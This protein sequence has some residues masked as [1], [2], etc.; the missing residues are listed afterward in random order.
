MGGGGGCAFSPALLGVAFRPVRLPLPCL[1]CLWGS[2][3]S[4]DDKIRPGLEAGG[5]LETQAAGCSPVSSRD[6]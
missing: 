1:G 5:E 4:L 6:S 3:D 2:G